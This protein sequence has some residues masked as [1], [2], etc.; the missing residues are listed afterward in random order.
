MPP[1]SD[2]DLTVHVGDFNTYAQEILDPASPLYTSWNPDIV[3][4]AVHTRDI[5]PEL[6]NGVRRARRR[7]GRRGRRPGDR[8]A[9]IARRRRSVARSAPTSSCTAWSSP[10]TSRLGARRSAQPRAARPARSP[11]SI[12]GSPSSSTACAAS[13]PRLRRA[14][15]PSAGARRW[16]DERK[17]AIMRMPISSPHLVRVADEWLR[18]V[19]PLVGR[20]AK[21]LAVDLDN[22][23][24]GGIDR[25]GRPRRHRPR[26]RGRRARR[27]SPL[28]R[29]LLDLRARGV[30]LA[31]CSKNNHDDARRGRS[32]ATR[33]C[34][35]GRRTSTPSRPTGT[36]RRATCWRDRRR[37]ERRHRRDRLPRRQPGR[38]QPRRPAAAGWSS[39]LPVADDPA[40]FAPAVRRSPLFERLSLSDEDRQRSEYYERERERA[41]AMA[42]AA[43]LEGFLESLRTRGRHLRGRPG[44]RRPRRPADA[45]DEPVQRHDAPL[46]ASRRSRRWS[47]TRRGRCTRCGPPTASATT[48]WSASRSS[49]HRRAVAHRHVPAQLP[50]DREAGGDGADPHALGRCVE[51]RRRPGRR[52]HPDGEERPCRRLLRSA[53][54]HADRRARATSVDGSGPPGAGR[55]TRRRGSRSEDPRE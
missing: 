36:T 44:R 38:A 31:V 23:L 1:S 22:T 55:S 35:C 18:F 39:V 25:R 47:T 41:E 21:V 48:G 24:W 5:A 29:A 4:L 43:T 13:L 9:R 34:C 42:G 12:A 14:S 26:R 11:R 17:W 52:V 2:I 33:R 27:S 16:F 32:T 3:V 8:R 46:H 50:G 51:R 10:P 19:H 49:T 37:P 40:A 30:L 53:R 28:Q 6:W 15:S 54:L 45:E 20:V 7:R